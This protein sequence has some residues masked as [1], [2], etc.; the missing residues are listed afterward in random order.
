MSNPSLP[1]LTTTT[2][3]PPTNQPL[4]GWIPFLFGKIKI[5][6]R[7]SFLLSV[8]MCVRTCLYPPP[9]WNTQRALFFPLSCHCF[10]MCVCTTK[11]KKK[12]KQSGVFA[13]FTTILT[14]TTVR[15][16]NGWLRYQ[17][18]YVVDSSLSLSQEFFFFTE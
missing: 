16:Y 11:V 1:F 13:V 4:Q 6:T 3:S 10:S 5:Y 18:V 8:C 12:K 14:E 7:F 15:C 9:T 2:T 17:S